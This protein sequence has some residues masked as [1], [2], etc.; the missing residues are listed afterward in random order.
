M[1]QAVSNEVL[2]NDTNA[3]RKDLFGVEH[4]RRAGGE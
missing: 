4:Q 3:N 1:K 2:D